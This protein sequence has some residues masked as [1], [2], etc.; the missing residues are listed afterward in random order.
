M[1]S[2]LWRK[3]SSLQQNLSSKN[4]D[5]TKSES[6][7]RSMAGREIFNGRNSIQQVL[8]GFRNKPNFQ[9]IVK[10]YHGLVLENVECDEG[11]QTA[12]EVTAGKRYAK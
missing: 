6:E 4:E 7:F 3:E 8:D 2:E 12:V 11:T 5:L 1:C 10:G 9:H